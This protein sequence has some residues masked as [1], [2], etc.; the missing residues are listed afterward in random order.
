MVNQV[1]VLKIAKQKLKLHKVYLL[2]HLGDP[3]P[4]EGAVDRKLFS[5]Q[6]DALGVIFHTLCTK[7]WGVLLL[8]LLPLISSMRLPS[9]LRLEN[10]PAH[11]LTE[12]SLRILPFVKPPF[13]FA[14]LIRVSSLVWSE[15][16]P[17][18][19]SLL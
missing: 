10:V 4:Y 15:N 7:V 2:K 5:Y 18:N 1:Y 12:L 11:T 14:F 13:D 3:Y 19:C 9:N 17:E 8:H 16:C 6:F